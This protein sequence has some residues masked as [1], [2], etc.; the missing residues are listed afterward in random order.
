[1]NKTKTTDKELKKSKNSDYDSIEYASTAPTDND[2][3]CYASSIEESSEND[4]KETILFQRSNI[5]PR[6][7]VYQERKKTDAAFS[8]RWKKGR[9]EFDELTVKHQQ[10][11]EQCTAGTVTKQ[12]LTEQIEDLSRQVYDQIPPEQLSS[13]QFQNNMYL[14]GLIILCV[15][16]VVSHI[17]A[18]WN[19][20]MNYFPCLSTNTEPNCEELKDHADQE[21]NSGRDDNYRYQNYYDKLESFVKNHS[22]QKECV[23]TPT[24]LNSF[25]RDE[26]LYM[27]EI[28]FTEQSSQSM[29]VTPPMKQPEPDTLNSSPSYMSRS[30]PI[31]LSETDSNNQTSEESIWGPTMENLT[32]MNLHVM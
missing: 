3:S 15:L 5:S 24:I 10:L 11:L 9:K 27:K 1:M 25:V 21:Y 28:V 18:N 19:H 13:L 8:P 12:Q 17:Y 7:F 29:H 30:R 32:S 6:K 2:K 4:N 23:I 16:L 14:A 26:L 20:L 22:I 31:I